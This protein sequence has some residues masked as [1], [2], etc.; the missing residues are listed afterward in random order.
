MENHLKSTFHKLATFSK[1]SFLRRLCELR[2]LVVKFQRTFGNQQELRFAFCGDT[3]MV[4]FQHLRQTPLVREMLSEHQDK[5][6]TGAKIRISVSGDDQK[7]GRC[8]LLSPSQTPVVTRP[9][10]RLSPLNERL[11]QVKRK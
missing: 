5:H 7:S 1:F 11:E 8:P 9:R 3:K 2:L 10:F 4:I 6:C